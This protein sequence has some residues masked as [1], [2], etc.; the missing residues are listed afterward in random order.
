MLDKGLILPIRYYDDNPKNPSGYAQYQAD[1]E[2]WL[3]DGY[4][5]LFSSVVVDSFSNL[6]ASQMRQTIHTD[7]TEMNLLRKADKQR[8]LP[9]PQIQ[10]YATTKLD[11]VTTFVQL[12]SVP[13][14][15]VLNGHVLEERK[16]QTLDNPNGFLQRGLN[17]NPALTAAIPGLFSELYYAERITSKP[18][19]PDDD[20]IYN[21][22]WTTTKTNRCPGLEFGSLMKRKDG[23]RIPDEVPQDFRA[24]LKSCGFH[25]E[26]KPPLI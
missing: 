21:Y 24:L 1:I 8:V 17:A 3:R 23:S 20:L 7:L 15:L 10:D 26:D 25:S 9:T 13:C 6:Q 16:G 11:S 18:K 5:E 4:F 22:V 12:A 2:N 19:D 14:H